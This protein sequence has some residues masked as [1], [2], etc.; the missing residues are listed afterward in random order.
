SHWK[1]GNVDWR[2]VGLLGVPG[3]TGAFLGA[4]ALSN[5]STAAAEP[6]MCVVLLTLGLYVVFRFAFRPVRKTQFTG[7]SAKFTAP[8]GLVAGFVDAT[9]GGGWGPVATPT[10]L[11]S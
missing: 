9:G 7:V 6:W 1:F 2:M 5:L 11:S 3:A 8:L 10:L 4:T